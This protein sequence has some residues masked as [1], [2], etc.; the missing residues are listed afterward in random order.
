MRI[1][2][3]FIAGF[4]ALAQ[5]GSA[6]LASY[7]LSLTITETGSGVVRAT[8]VS[9]FVVMDLDAGDMVLIEVDKKAGRFTFIYPS[10]FL[11]LQYSAGLNKDGTVLSLSGDSIGAVVAKG[12]NFYVNFFPFGGAYRI[13]KTFKV[14]GSTVDNSGETKITDYTGSF[15]FNKNDSANLNFHGYT[16][17][18]TVDLVRAALLA[19]GY[20]EE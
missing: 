11:L 9:G 14:T 16:L 12:Q 2:L 15:T 1:F 4:I 17:S 18:T 8:K 13:P 20:T 6:S 19:K 7:G 10:D 3:G 5:T